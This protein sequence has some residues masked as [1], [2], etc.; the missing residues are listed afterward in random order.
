M[1]KQAS[2]V[3]LVCLTALLISAC[4]D[5][6]TK[7]GVLSGYSKAQVPPG[8]ASTSS[9]TEGTYSRAAACDWKFTSSKS[10]GKYIDLKLNKVMARCNS[11]SKYYAYWNWTQTTAT[12]TQWLKNWCT[13]Q[14]GS[15]TT[16]IDTNEQQCSSGTGAYNSAA[17]G[18]VNKYSDLLRVYNARGGG[19]SKSLWGKN[20]YCNSGRSEGR[21]YSGLSSASCSASSTSTNTTSSTASSSSYEGYVNKYSDLLRVY[22]ARGRGQTKSAWGK[23]HYCNN[24]RKE[25]R[26]YPGLSAASCS[27]TT[28][29]TTTTSSNAFEGYVNKY[30]DL[31][32]AYNSAG[33]GQS[34]STWG[35]NHYCN[36]GR[37]AGR[38]YPGLSAASCSSTTTTTTTTT[39]SS[40]T[41]GSMSGLWVGSWT[42]STGQSGSLSARFTTSGNTFRG[43]A[44]IGNSFCFDREYATGTTV[45]SRV[46]IGIS[47][48]AI[49]FIGN[50]SGSNISGLYEVYSG[51]CR[52]DSGSFY[53]RKR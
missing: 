3:G 19:Q 5:S 22:N 46:S 42:S 31:L 51:R 53:L 12:L 7:S 50:L 8:E 44:N 17:V 4:S 24:G 15:T 45:G 52:G 20:H 21:N 29:T 9:I 36:A 41:S 47:S 1:I 13:S 6:G 23:S 28:T 14:H 32:A 27:S 49:V 30:R 43:P 25:G 16:I 37:A 39:T 40:S 11:V 48:N 10:S 34:K 38:T 18:Y 2:F 33:R 26:T 35:K